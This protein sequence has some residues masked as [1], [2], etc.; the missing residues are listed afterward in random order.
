M[1]LKIKTGT[2]KQAREIISKQDQVKGDL[3]SVNDITED[4]KTLVNSKIIKLIHDEV[5]DALDGK[6]EELADLEGRKL[7]KKELQT[8]TDNL[9]IE[10]EDLLVIQYLEA[11]LA[12]QNPHTREGYSKI[13]KKQIKISV[14]GGGDK[15]IL[16]RKPA[17]ITLRDI[18][19]GYKGGEDLL[20][21]GLIDVVSALFVS[22][23]Q[24]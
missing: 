20:R 10:I 16:F 5:K 22:Y 15:L 21:E 17:L 6:R 8:R 13:I 4:R 11:Q 1:P 24:M 18:L 12:S 2:L 19:Q 23:R 7:S 14:P 9:H 3:N